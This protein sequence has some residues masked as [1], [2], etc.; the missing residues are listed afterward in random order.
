MYKTPVQ[1]RDINNIFK[2]NED[3]KKI[4]NKNG[5]T[6]I[7]LERTKPREKIRGHNIPSAPGCHIDC[8]RMCSR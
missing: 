4:K 7:M 8:W 6:N 1:V 2:M 5:K 3:Q